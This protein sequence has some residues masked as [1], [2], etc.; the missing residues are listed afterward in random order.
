MRDYRSM[1]VE[2]SIAAYAEDYGR[3]QEKDA[4]IARLVKADMA[5]LKEYG[6]TEDGTRF[7]TLLDEANEAF[8]S[9]FFYSHYCPTFTDEEKIR[10]L[11][12]FKSLAMRAIEVHLYDK[13]EGELS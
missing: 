1:S 3:E 9:E 13:Y 6:F 4:Y 12:K 8:A 2:N 7:E 5:S 11:D 10:C